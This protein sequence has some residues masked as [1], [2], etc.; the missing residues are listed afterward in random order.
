MVTGNMKYVVK[1]HLMVPTLFEE[2]SGSATVPAS[3][4]YRQG[5]TAQ[6]LD[7]IS[8]DEENVIKSLEY[9]KSLER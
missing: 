9:I 8:T 6:M 2:N 5:Q 4:R 3:R 1:A 7:L